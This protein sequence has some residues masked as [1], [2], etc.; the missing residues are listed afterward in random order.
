MAIKDA[1]GDRQK[2]NYENRAKLYLYRRIPVIIRLDG[3]AF[4]TLTRRYCKKPFDDN[5]MDCMIEGAIA[6]A[7][8]AMGTKCVYIQSDE[9]TMLLTDFDTLTTQAWF[10]YNQEKMVSVSSGIMSGTFSLA[11]GKLGAF[12]SRAWNSPKEEVANNFYWR[13]RDWNRNSV[14]MFARSFFS[15]K[16]MHGKSVPQVHD[17]LHEIGENWA[18]LNDRYKNGVFITREEG[19]GWKVWDECPNFNTQRD[20]IEDLMIPKED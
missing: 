6:V 15:H 14:N 1:M 12:D 11:F 13:Q 19:S 8:E 7:K 3:K 18:L 17:M 2:K 10:D 4:H 9:V 16:K 5:L 20:V